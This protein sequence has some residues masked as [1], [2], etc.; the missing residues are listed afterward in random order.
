MTKNISKIVQEITITPFRTEEGVE[1]FSDTYLRQVFLRIAIEGTLHKVFF[2]K[3]IN[4]N[5]DFI[6]F[7]R[8]KQHSVFFVKSGEE[9]AGFFWLTRFNEK[10]AFITYCFYKNFWGKKSL[11]V[12]KYCLDYLLEKKNVRGDYQYDVLLGLTPVN[13]RLAINFLIKSGMQV[14]G[15][16]PGIFTDYQQNKGIDGL[17][18]YKNRDTSKMVGYSIFFPHS[19][20]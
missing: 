20:S 17:L 2:E 11:K 9:D 8:Q 15:K 7:T 13:N 19:I 18:S 3:K 10:S 14:L 16:I 1:F 4:N 6:A 5:E 12:S